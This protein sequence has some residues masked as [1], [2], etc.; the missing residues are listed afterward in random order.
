MR[1]TK[2][3]DWCLTRRILSGASRRVKNAVDK[4][5]LQEK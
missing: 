2:I 4:A 1:V 5:V 3:G